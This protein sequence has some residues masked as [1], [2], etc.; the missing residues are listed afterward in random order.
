MTWSRKYKRTKSN[1]TRKKSKELVPV[2]QPTNLHVKG[3]KNHELHQAEAQ[4][5]KV[6]TEMTPSPWPFESSRVYRL[7]KPKIWTLQVKKMLRE[8][9]KNKSLSCFNNSSKWSLLFFLFFSFFGLLGVWLRRIIL[10]LSH[11]YYSC[12]CLENSICGF[13]ILFEST[14]IFFLSI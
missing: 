5:L 4:P 13:Y 1:Y 7:V 8:W 14:Y 6:V 9:S 12:Q 3:W 10:K 11:C 2:S